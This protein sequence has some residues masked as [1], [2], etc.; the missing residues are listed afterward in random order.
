MVTQTSNHGY[1]RPEPGGDHDQWGELLNQTI[2]ALD[3]DV[4]IRDTRANQPDPGQEG[5]WFLPTDELP[6]APLE[7]DDGTAWVTIFDPADY[8]TQADADGRYLNAGGDTFDGNFTMPAGVRFEQ[9]PSGGYH[10]FYL[11]RNQID[12]AYSQ[13]ASL[14]QTYGTVIESDAILALVESDNQRLSGH[15]DLNND[16]F[17][18]EGDILVGPNSV[19]TTADEGTLDAGT[20]DGNDSAAFAARAQDETID[21]AWTFNGRPNFTSGYSEDGRERVKDGVWSASGVASTTYNLSRAY[22][23]VIVD[24]D[25]IEGSNSG[26]T[27]CRLRINGD[28]SGGY[29]YITGDGTRV[30]GQDHWR[31]GYFDPSGQ[32]GGGTLELQGRFPGRDCA[33]YGPIGVGSGGNDL[34]SGKQFQISSPLTTLEMFW[35]AGNIDLEATVFGVGL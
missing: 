31:V 8:L 29:D 2:D 20:L 30:T 27:Y 17:R 19:L 23:K 25:K 6:N 9:G 12:T 34:V 3:I 18:M 13:T 1:Q 28:A 11:R 15:F 7:Y 4:L 5:R 33:C 35:S 24:F 22:D 26:L 10:R 14:G 16:R 21:G 32:R